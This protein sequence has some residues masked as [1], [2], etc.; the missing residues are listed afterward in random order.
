MGWSAGMRRTDP[1]RELQRAT[2][3]EAVRHFG[4]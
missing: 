3:R 2:R 1:L 4:K